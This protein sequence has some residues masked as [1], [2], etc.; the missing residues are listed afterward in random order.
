MPGPAFHAVAPK[1]RK[2]R[3]LLTRLST[4][5]PHAGRASMSGRAESGGTV[6]GIDVA[7][8]VGAA[9]TSAADPA[10]AVTVPPPFM[11]VTGTVTEASSSEMPKAVRYGSAI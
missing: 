8:G 11:T 3:P 6:I 7:S 2:L 9:F 10:L 1:L 5:I 4:V